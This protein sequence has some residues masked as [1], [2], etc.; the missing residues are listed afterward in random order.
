MKVEFGVLLEKYQERFKIYS[1]K[2]SRNRAK[3]V[4]WEEV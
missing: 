4:V 2:G 3:E 1:N